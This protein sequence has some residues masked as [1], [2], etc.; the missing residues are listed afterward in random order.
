VSQR[1]D[2]R[3]N[4]RL[5]QLGAVLGLAVGVMASPASAQFL[6]ADFFASLPEPGQPAQVE[7]NT[8]AYDSGADVISAQGR[9]VM[10]YGGY[11]IACDE[12]RYDQQSGDAQCIGNVEVTDP[13]GNVV[14]A[15]RIE[16]TG[17]MKE[18]FIQSMT[19]TTSDGAQITA[20]DVRFASELETALNEA[21]YSPCGLCIDAKGQRI[22]WRVKAARMVHDSEKKTIYFEQP[23]LEV[24]GIP[25]AWLPWLSLPDPTQK[26][27]DGFMLPSINYN[28]DYGVRLTTPYFFSVGEDID[29]LLSPAL[30][31]RQGLLVAAEYQQRFD[32]GAFTV[33][34]SGINQ[35]DP[36]AFEGVGRREW[37]GALQTSGEFV[38]IPGWTLGWSYSAFTDPGYFEDYDFDTAGYGVN[39]VY[40]THVSRDFYADVRLQEFLKYGQ[41]EE[42]TLAQSDAAADLAQ[43]QQAATMPNARGAGYFDLGEWGQLRATASIQGVYRDADDLETFGG[44]PY[45]FGYEGDKTHATAEVSWQNQIITG[46]GIVVTPFISLRAD[47]TNYSSGDAVFDDGIGGY[48]TEPTDELLFNATPIAAIDVRFPLIASS[49][50]DSHLFE[51]IGQVVWRGSDT[52]AVGVTNDNAHSFV[53]D[54]TNIFSYDRFTGTDR[55]ETGLRANIGGRYLA[56]FS[57]GEWLEVVAGQSFHLAGVNAFGEVDAVNTGLSSGLEDD[58]SYLVL[59]LRGSPLYGLTVG[60]KVQIDTADMEVARAGLG[61]D[62][63]F[64]DGYSIGTDYIYLPADAAIGVPQDQHE[65]TLRASAPLPIDY[66][67]ASGSLS[68][69]LAS[70]EWLQARGEL[71]YDDGYFLAGGF[72]QANGPTHTSPDAVAFGVKFALKTPSGELVNVGY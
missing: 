50:A 68:W 47:A 8:L 6:P 44:V 17:G 29:I 63:D 14:R 12:L 2:R 15:E 13:D 70:N 5:R 57:G 21:S 23:S 33:S 54:D 59:G 71:V 49:G 41:Y 10:N 7:A 72:A 45:V 65:V 67:T 62:F 3:G 9:A 32:Y 1:R 64:G 36:D 19:I 39:E 58:A 52:S 4:V 22:G 28:E 53:L 20:R 66:F 43:D 27:S 38:P 40:A 56:N 30:M 60:G 42:P 16:V 37:R 46:G 48:P 26:R 61:G 35:L 55:Q 18:A 34:A 51:P 11:T 25:V 69:D 24:L 31:S